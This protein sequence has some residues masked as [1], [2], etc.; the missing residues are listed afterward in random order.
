[1]CQQVGVDPRL[2]QTVDR[3]W[4]RGLGYIQAARDRKR[5]GSAKPSEFVQMLGSEDRGARSASLV[6]AAATS[7]EGWPLDSDDRSRNEMA[8]E[9]E[10]LLQL[11]AL[12]T[13][14]AKWNPLGTS[15]SWDDFQTAVS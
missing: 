10:T 15:L 11:A 1:M 9:A 13:P 3:I 6:P 14:L 7:K 8:R 12:S 5:S 2:L 4:V